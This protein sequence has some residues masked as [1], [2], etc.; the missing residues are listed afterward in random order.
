MTALLMNA[1]KGRGRNRVRVPDDLSAITQRDAQAE[2]RPEAA[3]VSRQGV[4]AIWSAVEDLY[5]TG[6]QPAMSL[7]LRRR[8]QILIKRSIGYAQ[9]GGP[10]D[11]GVEPVLMTPDTPICLFSASKAITAMLIHKLVELGKLRLDDPVTDYLPEYAAGGKG[12][13]TIRHLLA[14]R[15]GIPQVAIS[16]VDPDVIFDWEAAVQM[17]CRAKPAY[18]RDTYQAYH[19][20]TAGFILGEI[21]RRVGGASLPALLKKWIAKPL[22]CEY[23]TYGLPAKKHEIAARNYSTGPRSVF[24]MTVFARRIL[25]VEFERVVDISNEP[26]FMSAIIPAGNIYAT[27]D[28]VGRFYQMML[29]RGELDG[30]RVFKAETIADATRPYGHITL[31]RSLL[32]PIR[33]SAGMI[34]GEWP[35]GLYGQNCPN[36]Y[37][38]L[39]FLTI[40]SWADPDRDISVSFLNTGKSLAPDGVL[41]ASKVLYQINSQ[42]RAI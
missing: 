40:L 8:G 19:A 4:E 10:D 3:G 39:G 26:Q 1:L 41:A 25:G 32:L 14:H 23:M 16:D 15:A 20:I 6:L 37:G 22:G 34:L 24:P 7:V 12:D 18:K 17:L 11:E 33:F 2:C 21:A 30:A 29:N 38:H 28:D 9:G 31:D 13:T 5:R 36:A 35:L 42:C 27:A